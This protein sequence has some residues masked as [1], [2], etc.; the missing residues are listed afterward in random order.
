MS[1]STI[2]FKKSDRIAYITLNRPEAL[3]GLTFEMMDEMNPQTTMQMSM[4]LG[5]VRGIFTQV[6]NAKDQDA[7]SEAV[8]AIVQ[9]A[10]MFR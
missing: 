4:M 10:Q 1:F 2:L 8:A 9:I 3:N 6:A 5:M 7:F